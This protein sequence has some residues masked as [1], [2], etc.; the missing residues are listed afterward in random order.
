MTESQ[1]LVLCAQDSANVLLVR[2]A[3]AADHF[4]LR[5]AQHLADALS[6]ARETSP[7]AVIVERGEFGSLRGW[8]TEHVYRHGRKFTAD[9]LVERVTGRPLTIEPYVRYLKGKFGE[10]YEL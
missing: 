6:L 1:P 5:E 8:L 10:L 2:R 9:Q 4:R 7:A 3:A